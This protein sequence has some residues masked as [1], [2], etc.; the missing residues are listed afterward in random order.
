MRSYYLFLACG[1]LS[2][3]T[4]SAQRLLLTSGYTRVGQA[5]FPGAPSVGLHGTFSFGRHLVLGLTGSAAR[6]RHDYRLFAGN[7]WGGGYWTTTVH[8]YAYSGH[9]LVGYRTS[10][11]R[12][13][14]LAVAASAGPNEVGHREVRGGLKLG[15]G[16][17]ANLSY[18][19]RPGSRL[20]LEAVLHPRVLS[21]GPMVFDAAVA[22]SDVN[23]L[24]LDAQLGVSL[25]L[26]R[27]PAKP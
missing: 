24:V 14:S 17:W 1:L 8:N 20:R 4:A 6:A 12:P 15:A 27:D 25:D 21:Q 22:F 26:R 10:Y 9:L 11:A 16:L 18:H 3:P 7:G 13:W 5:S 23:L 2:I 19:P